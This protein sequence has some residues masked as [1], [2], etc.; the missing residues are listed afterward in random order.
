MTLNVNRRSL[1]TGGAAAMVAPGIWTTPLPAAAQSG[2]PP[3]IVDITRARTEPI[4]IAI[5]DMAGTGAEGARL[6]QQISRVI[7]TVVSLPMPAGTRAGAAASN[8]AL[9]ALICCSRVNKAGR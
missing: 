2:N 3:T 1:L 7:T 6:G 4:P 8:S 9:R 5:P